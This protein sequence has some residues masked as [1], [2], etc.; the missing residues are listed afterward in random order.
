[1][2]FKVTPHKKTVGGTINTQTYAI[3]LKLKAQ[4]AEKPAANTLAVSLSSHYIILYVVS[5]L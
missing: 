3:D 5:L 2:R 1:M 4:T